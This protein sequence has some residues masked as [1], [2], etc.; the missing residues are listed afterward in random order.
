MATDEARGEL[1]RLRGV[2]PKDRRLRAALRWR[3]SRGVPGG[4]V[5]RARTA[6]VVLPETPA[7][8]Q[9]AA[10]VCRHALWPV[11]WLRAAVPVP[12]RPRSF[13]IEVTKDEFPEAGCFVVAG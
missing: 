6:A 12:P 13:E 11:R 9:A 4:C 10:Q 1:S 5:D 3:S 7:K 8:R 2:W